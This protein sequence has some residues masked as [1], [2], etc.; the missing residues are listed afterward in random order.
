MSSGQF[1]ALA[2]QF[3]NVGGGSISVKDVVSVDV[4][5]GA[6][7]IADTA[8]QIW[9]WN[10]ASAAWDKYFYRVQRG[11]VYGWCKSGETAA[12]TDEIPAGE[13]FFYRRGTGATATS[14]TLSGAVKEFSGSSQYTASSG[15]LVF[16]ANPWPVN[17]VIADFANYQGSATG[18]N[19]IADTADQ[20]WRWN[21]TSAAWDKYFYRVQRGTVY[22]WCKAGETAA[23]SDQIPAGEGFF[24]RRGTGSSLDTITL[25]APSAE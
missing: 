19:A 6:N 14:M 5:A 13:T 16:M 4:P 11:T 9:R 7:A 3:E 23:T 2:V 24:F 1:K 8:D 22:G 17:V 20:I 12:T 25:P 10:T 18:A 21:T 15:Q